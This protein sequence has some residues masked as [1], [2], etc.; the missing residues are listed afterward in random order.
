MINNSPERDAKPPPP[1]F[2]D[3]LASMIAKINSTDDTV[4][5]EGVVECRKLLIIVHVKSFLIESRSQQ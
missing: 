3:I 5:L 1:V 2:E 4:V